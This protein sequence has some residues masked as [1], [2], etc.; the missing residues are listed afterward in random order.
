VCGGRSGDGGR[1]WRLD[2]GRRIRGSR[3][4]RLDRGRRIRGSR[5]WRLDRGGRIRGGGGRGRRI[6]GGRGFSGVA[7]LLAGGSQ[8]SLPF[9]LRQGGLAPGLTLLLL[10]LGLLLRGQLAGPFAG[11]ANGRTSRS[12]RSAGGDE[13]TLLHRVGDD[14]AHQ[15]A[16]SDGVV[17]TGND[18]LDQVGIAVGIDDRDDG[19][20]ELVGL[21]DRDV[22][23]LGVDYEDCLREPGHASNAA[24]V[25]VQ[26]LELSAQDEGFL[27]RHGLE[28]A[29]RPHTVVLLHLADTTG[30]GAEVGEHA[31]EP[32]LV[33]V[34]HAALGGV[35]RDRILGLLLGP[36]EEDVPAVGDQIAY[37][38]V[39]GVDPF[40]RLA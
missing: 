36:D 34:R 18:V 33:D 37:E 39:G 30:D 14:P 15:A 27:L 2:R 16:G 25:P 21:R 12:G 10:A 1:G 8:S 19:Q 35:G 13:P 9:G 5:G 26:L 40:Q 7:A 20:A 11:G 28:V 32:P 31:A 38:G 17:V 22:L 24:Q 23:L 4:W 3:G 29:G 6:L